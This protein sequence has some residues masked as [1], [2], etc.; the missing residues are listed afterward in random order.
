[1]KSFFSA[2]LLAM[3]LSTSALAQTPNP[4]V[5]QKTSTEEEVLRTER[6]QR[7]A[8]LKRDIKTTERLVADEFVMNTPSGRGNKGTLLYVVG[9]E[10]A[11]PT[12]TLTAEDVLVKVNGDTAIVVGKRVE[13]RQNPGN[14]A[15]GTAYARY[16][17]T[18]IKRCAKGPTPGEA[19]ACQW[20]LLSEHLDT[21]PGERTAIKVDPAIYDDYVG[22]YDSAIMTFSVVREGD[23]LRAIPDDKRRPAMEIF[24]ESESQFFLKGPNAQIIFMRNRQGQVTHAIV[25]LNNADFQ[26]KRVG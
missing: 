17:R 4:Q 2:V 25:R 14:K 10:P 26:A 15:W 22:R 3:A 20:Q 21:I 12:L 6:E 13:K 16:T 7:D 23:R 8:Y 1:M 18:Y 24:P 19:P 9:E 5:N 11:D